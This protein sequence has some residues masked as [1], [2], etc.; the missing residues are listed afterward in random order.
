MSFCAILCCIGLLR[1]RRFG[2]ILF[3]ITYLM[4]LIAVPFLDALHNR[5]TTSQ[6]QGQAFPTL[7]FLVVTTAYFKKR[8]RL[9]ES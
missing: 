7:V 3:V 6:Q 5:A 2:V 8:W 9:M 1:R 4:L